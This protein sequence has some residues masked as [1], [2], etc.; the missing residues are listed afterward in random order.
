MFGSSVGGRIDDGTTDVDSS[1]LYGSE[2]LVA[3]ELL[4][5]S[6]VEGGEVEEDA[7]AVELLHPDNKQPHKTTER[8]AVAFFSVMILYPP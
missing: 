3:A 7:D 8:I 6:D 2:A 4:S 5:S 1:S